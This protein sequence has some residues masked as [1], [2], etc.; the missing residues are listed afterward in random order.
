[1]ERLEEEFLSFIINDLSCTVSLNLC[2]MV[3]LNGK[4]RAAVLK[5][6]VAKSFEEL[7]SNSQIHDLRP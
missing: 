3:P 2:L 6:M 5:L 7:E 4:C 1:M